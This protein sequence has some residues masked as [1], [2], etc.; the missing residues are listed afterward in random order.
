MNQPLVGIKRF[1]KTEMQHCIKDVM[2][3]VQLHW[4]VHESY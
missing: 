2:H 4:E 1:A 3:S